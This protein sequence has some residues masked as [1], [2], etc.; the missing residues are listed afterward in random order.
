MFDRYQT[1]YRQL[2]DAEKKAVGDIK[3]LASKLSELIEE[4]APG[5]RPSSIALTKLDECV[6]WATKSITR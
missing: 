1:E 4:T 5:G 2:T 6:M 3:N